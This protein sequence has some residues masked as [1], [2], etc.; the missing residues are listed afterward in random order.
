MEELRAYITKHYY[1]CT[2]EILKGLGQMYGA[3]GE[4]TENID[5]YAGKG[6]AAFAAQAIAEY[7]KS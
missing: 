1:T 2:P 7:C 5:R 4:M 3:G 6:T